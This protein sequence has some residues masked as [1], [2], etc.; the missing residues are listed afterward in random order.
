M[1]GHVE[2]RTAPLAVFSQRLGGLLFYDVGDAT[3]SLS[4][5]VPKHDVGFGLR[6]LIPQ[7]NSTVIRVDWAFATQSTTLTRAGFP[8]RAS[9]GF[10]QIF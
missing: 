4:A 6:W 3:T 1:I 9:A 10:Q 2:L 5:I 7:L 8:G